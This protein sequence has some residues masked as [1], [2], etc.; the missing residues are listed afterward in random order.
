P[1]LF[2]ERT[3]AIQKGM[4]DAR[5]ASAES[6]ARLSDIESRLARLDSDIADMRTKA[7]QDAKAEDERLRAATEEEKRKI[8]QTAEQDIA[9]ASNVARRELKQFAADLAGHLAEKK[10]VVNEAADKVLVRDF[11]MHLDGANAPKGGR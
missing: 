3:A 9:A 11:A 7:E 1:G 10:T 4:E 5:R 8:V 2:R 6:A